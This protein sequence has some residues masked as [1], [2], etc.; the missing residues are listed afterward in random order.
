MDENQESKLCRNLET[1][2]TDLPKQLKAVPL[3][4]LA[5]PGSHDSFTSTI[6]STSP[7]APDSGEL[8]LRLKWLGPL[9]GFPLKRWVRTQDYN[10][11]KQLK[12]GIRYFDLRIA[13]KDGTEQLFF[14]H[15]QY[16]DDV[17]SVLNEIE[18]FLDTH[19]KEVVIIDCQHFYDFTSRDH[20]RLM[21]LLKATFGVKLLPYS[22]TMDHLTLDFITER[23]DY[24]VIVIY[25]SDKARFNEPFLWPGASF[26]S[27]W[28]DTVSPTDL[29]TQL[30]DDINRRPLR[31]AFVSQCVLT[32]TC[33][34]IFR[35]LFGSLKS[36]CVI[37]LE[38]MKYK[39]LYNQTPGPR[40]VNV[41]ISD[42]IN[43]TE[44]KFAKAV[45]GLNEKLMWDDVSINGE[46]TLPRIE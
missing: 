9:L 26:P 40:G 41:I 2:M 13:T 22:T 15:G 45:I 43:M 20:D 14:V 28:P 21:Q 6:R 39:W 35:N 37:P 25:R 18:N 3:I 29:I 27:P 33:N 36:K 30:S 12:A 10:V 34:F 38:K 16:A 4:H 1:W 19:L 7:V 5:I 46:D 11:V 23:Y 42:F 24:Q 8:L 32:P 17:V 31:I 44:E